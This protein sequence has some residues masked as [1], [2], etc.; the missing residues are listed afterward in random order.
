MSENSFLIEFNK[1]TEDESRNSFIDGAFFKISCVL[2]FLVS[3]TRNGFFSNLWLSFSS[4]S[5]LWGSRK[6]MRALQN[7]SLLF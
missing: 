4:R 7:D 1:F 3:K 6:S 2:V 5:F